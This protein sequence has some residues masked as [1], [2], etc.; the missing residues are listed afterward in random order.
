MLCSYIKVLQ[1]DKQ[2]CLNV[3]TVNLS[4]VTD[5]FIAM[6]VWEIVFV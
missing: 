1:Y 2:A 4:S 3:M 6:L 5:T